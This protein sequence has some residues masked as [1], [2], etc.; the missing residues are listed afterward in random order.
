MQ[1]GV[2]L[3]EMGGPESW[4]LFDFKPYNWGPYS[5]GLTSTVAGL[6]SEEKITKV[7]VPLARY[8]SY[9]TTP[10]EAA[11]TTTLSPV[12]TNFVRRVREFVTSRSFA[13]LLRDVYAAH[14]DYATKSLFGG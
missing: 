13:Q 9:R 8:H 10:G 1:K 3:L 11:I 7:P 5:R 2:F 14:P 6:V 12:E 4:R